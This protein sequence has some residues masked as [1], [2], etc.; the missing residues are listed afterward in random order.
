M[1][2]RERDDPIEALSIFGGDDRLIS[3]YVRDELLRNLPKRQFRFMTRTAILH[4]PT[5]GLCDAVVGS[6]GSAALL[7]EL[8]RTNSLVKP[9][10]RCRRVPLSPA[11][12]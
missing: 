12:P 5:P 4:R 8:E 7:A 10:R 1:S 2:I 9:V 6:R 11:V 3:E